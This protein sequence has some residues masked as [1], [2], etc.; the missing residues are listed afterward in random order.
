MSKDDLY[1]IIYDVVTLD[2]EPGDKATCEYIIEHYD[3]EE[4]YAEFNED[5]E[6]FA[7]WVR[8][9]MY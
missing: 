1:D 9:F 2:D 6:K 4:V 3:V 8:T 5:M 7:N